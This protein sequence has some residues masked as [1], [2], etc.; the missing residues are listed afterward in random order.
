MDISEAINKVHE[1]IEG[2]YNLS[3]Q[4]LTEIESFLC[5][6]Q[7]E[8]EEKLTIRDNAVNF[9]CQSCGHMNEEIC[10]GCTAPYD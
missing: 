6:L 2:R 4:D 3:G 5:E 9:V 10:N 1:S 8:K 7:P